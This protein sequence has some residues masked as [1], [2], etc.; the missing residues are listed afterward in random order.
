MAIQ[1]DANIR[2]VGKVGDRVYYYRD[3]ILISRAYFIPVQPGT[4][5]QIA[6]WNQFR[7]GVTAW[8]RET[9]AEMEVYNTRAKPLR[10]S[11]FNLFMREWLNA[12]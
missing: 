3:G 4:D 6:W 7:R 1:T 11:G 2:T 9:P 10:M 12:V 8:H 5:G